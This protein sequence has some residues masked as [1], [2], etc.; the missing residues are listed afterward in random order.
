MDGAFA[1]ASRTARE[2]Q[3]G[4]RG[5]SKRAAINQ[6]AQKRVLGLQR[7]IG[8]QAVLRLL[9]ADDPTAMAASDRSSG[10]PL[11]PAMRVLMEARLGHDFSSVRI[12]SDQAAA[13]AAHHVNARA[14]TVGDDIVLGAGTPPPHS[15][16]GQRLLAHELAHVVQQRT[17]PEPS[18]AL[19]VSRPHDQAEMEAR[20]V[21]KALWGGGGWPL[22]LAPLGRPSSVVGGLTPTPVQV[23]RVDGPGRG[24]GGPSG[25]DLQNLSGLLRQ[26]LGSL[27]EG[28]RDTVTRNKTIAIGL[29]AD[30]DGDLQLVYSVSGN[31]TNPDLEA[32]AEKL[33][34][35]RWQ[36]TP[37]AAGR[38]QVGAP[39]DAEQLMVEAADTNDFKV[40]AMA[41]SRP[42]CPDCREEVHSHSRG[43]VAVVEV[44]FKGPTSQAGPRGGAPVPPKAAPPATEEVPAASEG[45]RRAATQVEP[46]P[47]P[48]RT[49]PPAAT[50][51]ASQ[52]ALR[53][54][55]QAP[56]V[57]EAVPQPKSPP[58]R[59]TLGGRPTLGARVGTFILDQIIGI[60]LD[61]MNAKL[62]EHR[63]QRRFEEG[64]RALQ[65][66]I[67]REKQQQLQALRTSYAAMSAR[68]QQSFALGP[69]YFNVRIRVRSLTT[70]WVASGRSG[71]I[72]TS[73][74]PELE[75]V[76]ISPNDV[77]SST[78]VLDNPLP[79]E[80][81]HAVIRIEHSQ[82]LT[83][84]E[85]LE[86]IP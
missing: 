72:T 75:S 28:T 2:A 41:V 15:R 79:I 55:R 36:A 52:P 56:T 62:K 39:G 21:S 71:S 6:T 60:L 73:P 61:L 81:G 14:F 68:R 4:A 83:Y 65:P 77:R 53:G 22:A 50:A 86:F 30:P 80:F 70:T 9:Q 18:G 29:V 7:T 33:G 37:R 66:Q 49:V 12:H 74:S 31:W 54:Q 10:E 43:G 1:F 58:L 38:G 16:D 19:E 42:V 48:T 67:E 69:L 24:G 64:M 47:A 11:D 20:A 5:A 76:T 13:Q 40:K 34:I 45:T 57:P 17:A 85:G 63:D 59:P 46:P 23:A 25:G 32:G 3:R 35:T 27:N 51:E 82:V 44:D 84:S 78:D 26:L 8:N